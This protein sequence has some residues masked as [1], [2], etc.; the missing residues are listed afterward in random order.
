ME[1]AWTKQLSVGNVILDSGHKY[2]TL[3]VNDAIRAVEARDC[4]TLLQELEHLE[5]WLHTHCTHEE[6]IAQP[7][8]FPVTLLKPAQQYSQSTLRHLRDEMESRYGLWSNDTA[9]YLSHLLRAWVIGHI[10]AVDMPIMPLL[11]TRGYNF[12]PGYAAEAAH[13]PMPAN[14]GTGKCGCRCDSFASVIK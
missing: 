3:I 13:A 11:Q 1:L 5:N 6:T 14:P 12:W 9:V 8:S 2:L 4:L 7:V 10:T